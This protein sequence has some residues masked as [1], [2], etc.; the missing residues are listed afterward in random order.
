MRLLMSVTSALVLAVVANGCSDS[1]SPQSIVGLWEMDS[2]PAGNSLD[3]S[4]ALNGSTVS[5]QGSWCGEALGCGST[6]VTGTA[7]GNS[8]HLVTTEDNGVVQTFDGSL[9][10]T[11]SLAGSVRESSGDGQIQLP[12]A[13]SFHRLAGDP[14]RTQ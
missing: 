11:N 14:P 3:M 4:L 12:H 6:S 13:Q 2:S 1:I 5:G 8:F 7:M 10:S 9:T